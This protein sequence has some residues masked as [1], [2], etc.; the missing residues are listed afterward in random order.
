[1]RICNIEVFNK[2]ILFRPVGATKTSDGYF[3]WKRLHGALSSL[4]NLVNI[5]CVTPPPLWEWLSSQIFH[6]M[7]QST[8]NNNDKKGKNW[9]PTDEGAS[10]NVSVAL[11]CVPP[12]C[13]SSSLRCIFLRCIFLRRTCV[14]CIFLCCIFLHWI[15][16]CCISQKLGRHALYR[17]RS[18]W[19]SLG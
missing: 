18:V 19:K 15:F 1:M 5:D 14:R 4:K 17:V 7:W 3:C 8:F 13:V 12:F 10:S 9:R 2:R 6:G 11:L 16:L